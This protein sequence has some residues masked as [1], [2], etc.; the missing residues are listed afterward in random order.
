MSLEGRGFQVIDTLEVYGII[1]NPDGT[2]KQLFSG[3]TS[4][5]DLDT[6]TEK[7]E[8]YSGIGN[9]RTFLMHD[10]KQMSMNVTI[11]AFDPEFLAY[12][13]GVDLD[14]TSRGT[15]Y[16]A[17][18]NSVTTGTCILEGATRVIALKDSNDKELQIITSGA[19]LVG[20]VKVDY[21]N[22][23]VGTLQVEKLTVASAPTSAGNVTVAFNDGTATT[24]TVALLASD[25]ASTAAGK[26]ANAFSGLAG[27]KVTSVN[28]DV[29]FTASAAASNKLV[30]ISLSDSGSTGV[31]SL[32]GSHV[33][34][35]VAAGISGVTLTF[36][37]SYTDPYVYATF[38][39]ELMD[40]SKDN[41]TINIS[42]KAFPKG[43]ELIG[44][45]VIYD[46]ENDQ[47]VGEFIAD[48]YNAIGDP[49]GTLTFETGKALS[50]PVQFDI[51]VPRHLPDGSLN[52]EKAIGKINIKEVA[53]ED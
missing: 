35:G 30:N 49:D 5:A 50:V 27:W 13:N 23:S 12:K 28:G 9:N 48:F 31:G 42:G 7:I 29:V 2:T 46:E 33:V 11:N 38:E 26:I 19:P 6:K 20:Q 14:K 21:T 15:L 24:E 47:K 40:S 43:L 25:T 41:W 22:G 18:K 36:H 34:N 51:T 1:H 39:G 3:E 32:T 53:S 44:K 37:S 4:K 16:M 10:K 45:T 52:T 17:Q 8:V